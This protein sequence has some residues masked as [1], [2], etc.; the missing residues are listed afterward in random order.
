MKTRTKYVFWLACVLVAA[1]AVPAA[2]GGQSATEALARVRASLGYERLQSRANGVIAEGTTRYRGLDSKFTF[3]FTPD[4]RFRSEIA[5]PLGSITGFDGTTGWEIDWS[6]IQRTLELQDL[7]AAQF[8]AWI[9]SGRWLDQSGPFAVSLDSAKSDDRQVALKLLLKGGLL[10]ATVFVDRATWLPKRV[11]RRGTGGEEVIEMSDYREVM[12]FRFPHRLTRAVG[13]TTNVYEIRSVAAATPA[14]RSRFK[15]IATRPADTRWDASVPARVEVR[16]VRS[17]H[18]LV[19]PLVNGKDAGWFILDSGAGA[20]VIDTKVAD[21]LGMPALGEI[22]AVGVA[23]TTKA[24]FRQGETF[25]LGPLTVNGTRY[26]ELDLGFLTKAFGLPIGGICG[27][28]LFARAVVEI[29]I[30]A[31]SVAIHDPN[32]YRLDGATWQE[33]FFSNRN[34]AVRARF[35]GHEGLFK[36][37]TGSDQTVSIHAPAVERLNL[38]SGRETRESRSGGVGGSRASLT[39]KLA[40]FELAGH[41]FESPLVEFA[42][43]GEGAFSDVYTTGNIGAAFLRAFRIVFDYG[44]KRVAFAPLKA[45]KAAGAGR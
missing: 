29:E 40:W 42:G 11:T 39:G 26:L 38:L 36:L 10:E 9:H 7:E 25:G 30:A 22:V 24:R 28:D 13:G 16:R 14:S 3:L 32:R 8:D 44:N 34:P 18:L 6:G 4:G 43:K 5:G 41:R 15:A 23:G 33:L 31:E 2:Q 45:T 20:M 37:D 21:R 1:M 17:G 27:R 19:H 35:E 12:G